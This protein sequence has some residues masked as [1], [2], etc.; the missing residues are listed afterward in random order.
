MQYLPAEEVVDPYLRTLTTDSSGDIISLTVASDVN[1]S[2]YTVPNSSVSPKKS[3]YPTPLPT[4][5]ESEQSQP[6]A[7]GPSPTTRTP[8]QFHLPS[9]ASQ[10]SYPSSPTSPRVPTTPVHS[11]RQLKSFSSF[12]P[13]SNS[14]DTQQTSTPTTPSFVYA[15][16]VKILHVPSGCA[17]MLRVPRTVSFLEL[18]QRISRKFEDVESL[19]P[20]VWDGSA[21]KPKKLV[22]YKRV[23]GVQTR[24]PPLSPRVGNIGRSRSAS[25]ASN[26]HQEILPPTDFVRIDS[27]EDWTIA[28][29]NTGEEKMSLR[30]HE[31]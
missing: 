1:H 19:P 26:A 21:E 18:R 13:R 4:H 30:I 25:T 27:E 16:S 22:L 28:V 23:G 7:P 6:M 2:S 29:S 24:S 10:T 17:V 5:F 12:R 11:L 20:F 15:I 31:Q 3:H 9:V 8:R 14:S